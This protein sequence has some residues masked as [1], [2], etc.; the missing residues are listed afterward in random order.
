VIL[1]MSCSSCGEVD[2]PS[3]DILLL[4]QDG[5]EEGTYCF[6]CPECDELQD[7]PASATIAALLEAL[8]VPLG[9]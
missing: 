2:L 7:K 6:V 1:R 4:V 5:D 9:H 3:N 8:G